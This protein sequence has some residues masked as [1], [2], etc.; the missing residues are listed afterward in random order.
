MMKTQI[1]IY[2]LLGLAGCVTAQPAHKLTEGMPERDV[3]EAIRSAGGKEVIMQIIPETETELVRTYMLPG[4]RTIMVVTS[5]QTKLV[6]ELS[7]YANPPRPKIDHQWKRVKEII[8]TKG[9]Q[10]PP[11]RNKKKASFVSGID[12]KEKIK[13]GR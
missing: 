4:K 11:K 3:T 13:F 8:L 10:Q 7:V 5:K 2:V 12:G 1:V 6:S 9:S